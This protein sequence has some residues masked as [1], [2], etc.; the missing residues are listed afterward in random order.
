MNTRHTPCQASSEERNEGEALSQI[1]T[2]L[3]FTLYYTYI[4]WLLCQ[5]NSFSNAIWLIF[6]LNRTPVYYSNH[7]KHHQHLS[8]ILQEISDFSRYEKNTWRGA[9]TFFMHL[10][11]Y[12]NSFLH[13]IKFQ[14]QSV[15]MT[16]QFV[17]NFI[18]C[19]LGEGWVWQP[20]KG[21]VKTIIA[22]IGQKII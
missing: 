11:F 12:K 15:T 14:F 2:W 9:A 20:G 21:M 22:V 16:R 6:K 17:P 1:W 7:H 3:N 18:I 4:Q 8:F 19:F 13:F 10:H 5:I